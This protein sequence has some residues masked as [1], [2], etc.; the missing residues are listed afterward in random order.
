MV[1]VR[2]TWETRPTVEG[3]GITVSWEKGGAKQGEHLKFMGQRLG[4]QAEAHQPF[5]NS[6]KG[7]LGL[8]LVHVSLSEQ[9][10]QAS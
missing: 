4:G 1:A 5:N 9:V 10:R 8:H 3:S 2:T 7:V 6:V